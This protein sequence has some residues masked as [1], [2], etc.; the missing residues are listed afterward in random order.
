[1]DDDS[2]P[3]HLEGHTPSQHLSQSDAIDQMRS[4]PIQFRVRDVFKGLNSDEHLLNLSLVKDS[5]DNQK[6]LREV[7]VG[8]MKEAKIFHE[9]TAGNADEHSAH[10]TSPGSTEMHIVTPADEITTNNISTK[11]KQDHIKE[12]G[13]EDE[14][15]TFFLFPFSPF[16][17]SYYAPHHFTI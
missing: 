5:T 8:E 12:E 16:P 9:L 10:S 2:I 1:M 3:L 7:S 15:L 11:Q 17:S 13:Q 14:G 4:S 6:G